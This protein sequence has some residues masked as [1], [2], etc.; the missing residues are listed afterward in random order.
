MTNRIKRI[1]S[2]FVRLMLT[3]LKNLA[4][5]SVILEGKVC[6]YSHTSLV[7]ISSVRALAY[8]KKISKKSSQTY[9]QHQQNFNPFFLGFEA[10]VQKSSTGVIKCKY[11]GFCSQKYRSLRQKAIWQSNF[12]LYID[13]S[14]P[15]ASSCMHKSHTIDSSGSLLQPSGISAWYHWQYDRCNIWV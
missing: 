14:D 15:Y 3:R 10:D 7:M 12:Q 2:P 4:N 9:E 8:S 13:V 1:D 5:K 11:I 6:C